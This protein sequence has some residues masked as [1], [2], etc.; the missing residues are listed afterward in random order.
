[1]SPLYALFATGTGRLVWNFWRLL[2]ICN[3]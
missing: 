2:F 3:D 1:M